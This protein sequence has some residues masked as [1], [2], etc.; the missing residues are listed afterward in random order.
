MP[1]HSEAPDRCCLATLLVPSRQAVSARPRNGFI[2]ADETSGSEAKPQNTVRMRILAV[3]SFT[4]NT[5]VNWR[6]KPK[7]KPQNTESCLR[8]TSVFRDL[9]F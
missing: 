6:Q 7:V 2:G 4:Q 5:V 1:W 9:H 3:C 8:P